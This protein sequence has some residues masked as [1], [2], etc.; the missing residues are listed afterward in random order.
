[1]GDSASSYSGWTTDAMTKYDIGNFINFKIKY[2]TLNSSNY[3]TQL[4]H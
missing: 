3:L 4:I 1:M 2:I